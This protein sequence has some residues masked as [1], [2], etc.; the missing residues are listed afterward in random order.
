MTLVEIIEQECLPNRNCMLTVQDA[1]GE[2]GFLYFKDAQLIEVNY[3][4]MWGVDAL[5]RIMR[6][7]LETHALAELPMGIK[8]SLWDPIEVLLAKVNEDPLLAAPVGTAVTPEEGSNPLHA[9][10]QQVP[11]FLAVFEKSSS[12]YELGCG[13]PGFPLTPAMLDDLD[14]QGGVFGSGLGAGYITDWSFDTGTHRVIRIASSML[15]V[16]IVGSNMGIGEEF[17][18]ECQRALEQAA[19]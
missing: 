3:G 16:V 11:G 15:A 6:W 8:R 5:A 14:D 12:G 4:G 7:N 17:D 1:K 13:D 18:A 10:L 9:L 19:A 2:T